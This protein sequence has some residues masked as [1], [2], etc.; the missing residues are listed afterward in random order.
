MVDVK[1]RIGPDSS[2]GDDSM[3]G[4]DIKEYSYPVYFSRKNICVSCGAEGELKFVNI[5]GKEV[6]HE[7]HPFEYLKCQRCGAR[8]SIKWERDSSDDKL[9][10]SAV[11]KR[12]VD[13]FL[14]NFIKKSDKI[15]EFD[16]D[17]RSESE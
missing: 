14:N 10:P 9:Y 7:V 8:Y 13:D 1:L 11:D 5:F 16:N 12:S 3:I 6:S 17:A 2:V 15:K 4:V